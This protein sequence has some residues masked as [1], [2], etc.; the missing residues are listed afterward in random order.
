MSLGIQAPGSSLEGEESLGR[1][2][3]HRSDLQHLFRQTSANASADRPENGDRNELR[4]DHNESG[5]HGIHSRR[6]T[7]EKKPWLELYVSFF[8]GALLVAPAGTVHADD[9]GTEAA[10]SEETAA[11]ETTEAEASEEDVRKPRPKKRREAVKT[12]GYEVSRYASR[13]GR[14]S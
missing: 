7:R 1:R 11:A 14:W 3:A 13:A 9:E 4:K 5:R 12:F 10:D 2:Y 8:L 6:T